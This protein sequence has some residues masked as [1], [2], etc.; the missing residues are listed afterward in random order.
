MR[1]PNCDTP[2]ERGNCRILQTRSDTIE[3]KIR[4]RKC[5]N[6]DH[7]WWTVETDLPDGAVKWTEATDPDSNFHS[8]PIRQPGFKR[9]SYS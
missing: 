6:C 2:A 5:M 1:C 8:M 3:S 7:K 9:V 4:Q